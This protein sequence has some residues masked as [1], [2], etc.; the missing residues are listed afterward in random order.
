[1]FQRIITSNLTLNIKGYYQH[2]LQ[3][4]NISFIINNNY[5]YRPHLRLH[6]NAVENNTT[7][8]NNKKKKKWI[9]QVHVDTGIDWISWKEYPQI[10]L[11]KALLPSS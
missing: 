8:T 9:C 10:S 4:S 7:I 1:M 2:L 11:N 3:K 6:I 5:S